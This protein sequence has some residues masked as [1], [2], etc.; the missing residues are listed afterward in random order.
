MDAPTVSFITVCYNGYK[1]TCELIESLRLHIRSV[2]FEVIVVDNASKQNEAEMLSA[3]YGE[4][5]FAIRSEANLG[6]AGGNNLGIRASRGAFLCFI[7]NDTYVE[8]DGIGYLIDRLQQNPRIGGVSPKLRV[9]CPPQTIQCAGFTPLSPITLR[10]ATIGY[11]EPD[12]GRFDQPTE[13]PYLHGAA[14]II[15]REVIENVGEMPELFFLYY[16]ELD[17]C[18]HITKAGYTLWYDP[19]WTV[20]HKESQST[21]AES[22]MKVFYLTRNRL[23]YA[24]RNLPTSRKYLSVCYQCT[25][26]IL[27]S[28]I[29]Y[30][31]QRK[32]SLIAAT[33][34]GVGGFFAL[35]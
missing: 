24:W 21:G 32:F 7:N 23:L 31:L 8:D 10:N 25:L 16:E 35:Q 34:R 3:K 2:S 29:Q 1:D 27:K 14:M 6:F 28:T 12:D 18:T 5:I 26:P 4:A 22:P 33:F 11:G 13:T 9:A 30:L 15:K 19:R 20:F 17:W